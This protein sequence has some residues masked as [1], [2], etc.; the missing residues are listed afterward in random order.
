M[1]VVQSGVTLVDMPANWWPI[2]SYG[3]LRFY[4]D[5]NYDYATIYR[6][7]PNVRTC[8]DFLARNIAQLGL[9]VFRRVSDTDRQ[10]LRDHPLA[11]VLSRPLPAEYKVTYY[12]LMESLV[13]DLGVYF[14]AYWLKVA[15]DGAPAG[16]LRVLPPQ[17]KVRGNL[18]PTGYEVTLNGRPPKVYKPSQVVHIR[19]YNAENAIIGLAPL[20]TL[21]RILAEEHAAG[22]YRENFW[23][24]SARMQ[25]VI[26]RPEKAPEWSDQARER[27]RE[28][29]AEMYSG[30]EN[31]GKTAILE[32]GMTWKPGGFNA[33]ESE[34]LLGR[35][36]TR[37][38][39]ARAYHIPPPLVGILDHAT[40]SNIK[41]QHKHLY[42]DVLGPWCACIEQ[43][44]E[45]QL[46]PEF[47]DTNGV[48][49][50][51]NIQEKLQGSFEEQVQSLQS[52]VGRP[53]MAGD[54]ARARFNLPSMG[55]DMAR[56]VLPLNVLVGGQASPRDVEGP[57]GASWDDSRIAP[58]AK[59]LDLH[60]QEL[61]ERHEEKWRAALVRHYKRQEAA[62]VSRVPEKAAKVDIGG[63]WWD[64][65]RWD[66]EL[67]EDLLPLNVLTATEWAELAA[68]ALEAQVDAERMQAWLRE[69]SRIQA[70]YI[71]GYTRDQ[72]ATALRGPEPRDAVKGVFEAALTVWAVREAMSA[73]TTAQNFGAVEGAAAGGMRYKTWQVNSS[74]PRDDHVALDGVRVGI[75]DRFPNG[76]RWPGDP[77]GDAAQNAN[78]QC[79]VRFS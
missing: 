37:E 74:N 13:G 50:E 16:L 44:V 7:Q 20:E 30:A 60:N 64:D 58:T 73:V 9:H 34:Y 29:W 52:A 17:V 59:A 25:G 65:E 76:L 61:R 42:Q 27:F 2:G 24:S 72:L 11:R 55:G 63:V 78:C 47:E 70:A 23:K 46:L 54:E 1:T 67:Y 33:Q 32:E 57:Q 51:F 5:Y 40:F 53:W 4:N 15:V 28:E 22:D 49:V 68:R 71:N 21:R 36:L 77:Q 66:R 6:T 14:N 56:P 8:V 39:C 75:R 48:Y 19:G 45:L 18:V 62:I 69:H 31:S 12:R 41:E 38:E 10:R 79:T 3:S 35:K 43:D 26:E